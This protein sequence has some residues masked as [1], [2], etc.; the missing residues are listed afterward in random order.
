MIDKVHRITKKIVIAIAGG[1]IV[2]GGLALVPLPGPGWLI[3]LA[4]L[5]VWAIEFHWARRLL[6]F[7]RAQLHRWWHWIGRQ[8]WWVKTLVGLATT[9]FVAAVV[10]ASLWVGLGRDGITHLWD[11][12]RQ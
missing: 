7:T 10:A 12:L 1:V 11:V 2:A 3:V 6:T 8:R 9:I 5:G 4:G